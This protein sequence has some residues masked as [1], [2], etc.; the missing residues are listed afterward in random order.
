MVLRI[1]S[2]IHKYVESTNLGM[3]SLR[4]ACQFWL[5]ESDHVLDPYG[6]FRLEGSLTYWKVYEI[7][8]SF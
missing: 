3:I 8:N 5:G 2:R 4:Q 7:L 1:R 6:Y